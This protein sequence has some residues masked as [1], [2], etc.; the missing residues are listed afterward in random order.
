MTEEQKEKNEE[1]LMAASK[2]L[3]AYCILT[4]SNPLEITIKADNDEWTIQMF[5]TDQPGDG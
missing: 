4:E 1:Y 2:A 3:V 5:K